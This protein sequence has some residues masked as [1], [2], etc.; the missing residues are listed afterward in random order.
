MK[1]FNQNLLKNAKKMKKTGEMEFTQIPFNLILRKFTL[2][3]LRKITFFYVNLRNFTIFGA[4]VI[5]EP[6]FTGSPEIC[7]LRKNVNHN[8]K[9]TGKMCEIGSQK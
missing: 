6:W 9:F 8:S 3:I 2:V 7:E 1:N 5:C 4:G